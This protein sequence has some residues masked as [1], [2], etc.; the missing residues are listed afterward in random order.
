MD[1]KAIRH[2]LAENW[3][4]FALLVWVNACLGASLGVDRQVAPALA[5]SWGLGA[6]GLSLVAA[7]GLTKALMNLVAGQGM[8]RWGRRPVLVLGWL[9]A[10]PVP[11]LLWAWPGAWGL[12]LAHLCLGAS[13]G[14]AWSAAV[15][16]KIDLVGPRGRGLAL[17][18]NE[19]A[20][21]ASV[22]LGAWAAGWLGAQA[23]GGSLALGAAVALGLLGLTLSVALVQETLPWALAEAQQAPEDAALPWPRA[24]LLGVSQAGFTNNLNDG[25]VWVLAPGYLA[26]QGALGPQAVAL[27]VGLYPLVWGFGQLV[28]GPLSDRVGRRWP[29]ALGLLL[30]A[31]ALGLMVAWPQPFPLW[32]AAVGLGLGTALVYPSLL[33]AVGDLVP[34]AQ[35]AQ[36]LGRYR[37]WRDLGY[38][39]GAGVG[40]AMLWWAGPA[41][42]LGGVGLLTGLSGLWLAWALAPARAGAPS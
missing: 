13:Q 23:P 2:G 20:G 1:G 17:G 33:A 28:A 26:A 36:A 24:A 31:L 16:M 37:F 7:F 35:R 15:V 25:V 42:A 21:Y 4:Q 29:A 8:A 10:L 39:A 3:P 18:L 30:Q 34:P 14:L 5:A 19:F 11:L 6:W 27:W 12:V 40:A 32:G 22:G 9:L 38:V 41:W